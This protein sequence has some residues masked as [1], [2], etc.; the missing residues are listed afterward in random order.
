MVWCWG[1]N[2]MGQLGLGTNV[3]HTT[4]H[5]VSSLGAAV[6]Q[7]TAGGN[8]TC[9]L[10]R[11]GDAI[12]WGENASGQLGDGSFNNRSYPQQYVNAIDSWRY[13]AAGYYHTCGI[14]SNGGVACW[15]DD[16]HGQ[17]G[18][19]MTLNEDSPFDTPILQGAAEIA[20]GELHSCA[21]TQSGG[22]KCWGNNNYGQVGDGTQW[23]DRLAPVD[24][25]GL[26]SGVKEIAAGY[27]HN[28]ALTESGEVFCWGLNS[29]G[30]LGNGNTSTQTSPAAC[31]VTTV[32][33]TYAS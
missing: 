11:A 21:L 28:C 6:I 22:V 10:T 16:S 17:L 30:Q 24:V 7:V 14:F 8:H 27:F 32:M 5:S 13:I 2:G 12:C 26:E 23:N 19:G 25:V 9:A 20:L 18:D 1:Y 33:N 4:P 3:S 15:G 31:N 29:N